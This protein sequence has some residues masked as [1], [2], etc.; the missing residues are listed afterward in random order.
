MDPIIPPPPPTINSSRYFT[1][2][3]DYEKGFA[4]FYETNIRPSI[5]QLETLRL[6]KIEEI[7]KNTPKANLILYGAIA[8]GIVLTYLTKNL[9]FLIFSG[10]VAAIV[11]Y[12]IIAQ[13]KQE[14]NSNFKAKIIPKILEFFGDFKYQGGTGISVDII[15]Q[16]QLLDHFTS[17][18]FEDTITGKYREKSLQFSETTLIQ[19]SGKHSTTIFEGKM[20]L[21]E[22]NRSVSGK[23][24]I[25]RDA[26]KGLW[27]GLT[28]KSHGL[29]KMPIQD[30]EF[31]K[32]FEVYAED[33][34]EAQSVVTP[35][36]TSKLLQMNETYKSSSIRCSFFENK[37]VLALSSDSSE[38]LFE[39]SAMQGTME[40]SMMDDIHKFLKQFQGILEILDALNVVKKG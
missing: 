36:F 31:E 22:L 38:N 11:R 6:Q 7:K 26:S 19:G 21:L 4:D 23:I 27:E 20:I 10:V 15:N 17:S 32:I 35:E 24:V 12:A 37:I 30:P 1:E 33:G 34:N 14:F 25:K 3:A 8:L 18:Y 13:P 28:G 9:G 16:S 40:S 39:P 2:T 5:R 29:K